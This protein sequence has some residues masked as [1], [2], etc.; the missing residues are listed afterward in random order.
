LTIPHK[1]KTTESTYFVTANVLERKNLFQV[2]KIA[3]LFLEVL[4]GLPGS[5]E[6]SVA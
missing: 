2:D 6:I 5:E 3:R 4:H 1:G